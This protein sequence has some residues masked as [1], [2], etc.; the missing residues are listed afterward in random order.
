MSGQPVAE[1]YAQ[2]T[3]W[4]VLSQTDF[5]NDWLAR[6]VFI[7][8]LA[9]LLIRLLPTAGAKSPWL[10]AAA[11]IFAASLVG[12]L[13]WAGHAIGAQ[14]IEGIVHPIADVLH[15]IGAAAWVGTLVPLALL[16]S[17]TGD[18]LAV[19][20]TAILRFSTLGLAS[21][22]T[23]LL[24]GII[25]TWYLAGSVS[26]LTGS[27]YGRLLLIKLALFLIMVGIAVFNWSQLTPKL[28]RNADGGA[29][30]KARRALCRNAAIEASCGAAIIGIVAVL[31]TLPPASHAGHEASSGAVRGDAFFRRIHGEGGMADVRIESGQSRTRSLHPG[32]Q[33]N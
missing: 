33:A 13:A 30:R 9:G 12:S 17:M 19:A 25:N 16:L 32:L 7:C 28:V 10:K 6:S 3:L 5:G 31:G 29:A 23:L 15:L 27:T 20:R 14:G 21:V 24:T 26:A 18:K 11:V 1:V 8:V 4:T 2:G 22:G